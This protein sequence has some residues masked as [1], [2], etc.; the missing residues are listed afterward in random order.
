VW[1]NQTTRSYKDVPAYYD[2]PS[3]FTAILDYRFGNGEGPVLAGIHPVEN[4]G[5][6][7]V[8]SA[9]SGYPYTLVGVY[10]EA[11][12]SPQGPLN[13]EVPVNSRRV[14]S[15]YRADLK[16]DRA[17]EI[18]GTTLSLYLWILNLLDR[19]NVID[20]WLSSGQPHTTGWANTSDGQVWI[21]QNETITDASLLTGEQKLLLR[22]ND[23]LHYDTGRQIRFGARLSF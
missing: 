20:V 16:A 2:Q 14:E 11:S 15:T 12:I 3:V 22:E 19:R 5:I 4:L 9:A 13:P 10:H 1:Q 6:N 21:E 23:P 18:S 8:V 17:F 7:F